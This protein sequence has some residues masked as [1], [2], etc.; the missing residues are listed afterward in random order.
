[1][2][3]SRDTDLRLRSVAVDEKLATR[4]IS[5]EKVQRRTGKEEIAN[6]HKV[7]EVEFKLAAGPLSPDRNVC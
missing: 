7:L 6:H 5:I 4:S 3:P 2:L 1:M